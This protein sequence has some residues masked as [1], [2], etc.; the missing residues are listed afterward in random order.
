MFDSPFFADPASLAQGALAGLIFGFLLQRG[1]VTRYRVILGQFLLKDFTVLKVMMTA[2]V[3]G[4]VG[5]YGML[6]TGMLGEGAMHLKSATLLGN[7]LG[8]VIFGVGMAVLGYCP[9]TGVGAMADGSRHAI[10][11][12][13]GMIAGA[14]VF[15]ELYPWVNRTFLKVGD[16]GKVTV[17]QETGL[18]PWWFILAMAVIAVAGFLALERH[19]HHH[20]EA[21][22][23]AAPA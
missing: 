17:S 21:P 6:A 23:S 8:G 7:A 12:V 11:G 3:V 1:G 20:P 10:F 9:G 22:G 19:E 4:A 16:L 14:A 2:I 18:S 5:I 13:L 15:A